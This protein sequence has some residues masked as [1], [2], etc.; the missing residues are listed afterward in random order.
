MIFARDPEHAKK[1]NSRI[2]PGIQG[3]PLM[4]VIA[5]KAVA[6]GEALRPEFTTYMKT[7]KDGANAM[8][9]RFKALG[10][11]VVSNGT[12]NHLF[13][14]N[15]MSQGV[16]GKEA[17]DLLHKVHITV[18]KNLIPFDTQPAQKG[19][20][21]RIGTPAIVSR[22][23]G[24][25]ECIEVANLIDAAL[26]GRNDAAVIEKTAAASLALCKKFPLYPGMK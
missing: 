5:A 23:F 13:S 15:V 14:L 6:F 7:V 12:D 20:G 26:K 4:H 24:V 9:E 11:Q 16:N 19:S 2:F 21:I 8:A 22:G 18:N 25:S 1:M 3:G 10:W 17:E